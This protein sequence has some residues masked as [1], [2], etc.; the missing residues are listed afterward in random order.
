MQTGLELP[1]QAKRKRGDFPTKPRGVRKWLD[2]LAHVDVREATRRFS[3]GIYQ[4]NRLR[5][6]AKRRLEIM[7]MLRP[8]AREIFDHLGGRIQAQTLPLPERT[9]KVFDLDLQ[10]LRETAFGY[11]A[12]LAALTGS[13]WPSARRAIALAAERAL[14]ARGEIMLRCAQVYSPLPEGFWQ[15]THTVYARTEAA[16]AQDRR[17]RDPELQVAKRPR[18]SPRTMYKRLVMFAVAQTDGLRKAETERV[19]SA[20]EAWA[21]QAQLRAADPDRE[22]ASNT[23]DVD[24]RFAVDLAESSPPRPWRLHPRGSS[25]ALRVLDLWRV[26]GTINARLEEAERQ[27]RT[28]E[29][30]NPDRISSVALRRLLDNW[31][32]QAV[33]RSER[34]QHGQAVEVEVTLQ[35]IHDRCELEQ[36][37]RAKQQ[38]PAS[39]PDF[40]D[41][42]GLALQTIDRD[43]RA[44]DR[45]GFV[46]HPGH[47][48]DAA[49]YSLW[50]AVA[51]GRPHTQSFVDTELPH[52]A[53]RGDD[54]HQ[55]HW[56]LE[57]SSRSGFR[58][59]W[60]GEG[61][62]RATVGELVA[63]RLP[64]GQED[65]PRW[66]LGAVRWIQFVGEADFMAGCA[67]LSDHMSPAR[68]ERDTPKRKRRGHKPSVES[69]THALVL[70][71][72]RSR[73]QAAGVLV[74][75]H[76][77]HE[78][79]IVQLTLR[80][81]TLRVE[82]SYI[83]EH[84]G[85]FTHFDIVS[86]RR[87][88][89]GGE[90]NGAKG[91]SVWETI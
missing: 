42:A 56:I 62:S 81:R 22:G 6:P 4:L 51:R 38:G 33:R 21:Q 65:A 47:G 50:D 91:R 70:P 84:T 17:V 13:R 5:I 19:Y 37:A 18:Q 77:F 30:V 31:Q 3:E 90:A 29:K 40:T 26:I 14:T 15:R 49:H 25:A 46:T 83:R 67:A 76:M 66:R 78:G 68:V 36:Q 79:E 48:Q 2:E 71:G 57:D 44:D 75:A 23:G 35:R 39:Q 54:E 86:A 88:V 24:C 53:S 61:S 87:A 80:Q 45:Q 1:S 82:L 10:L 20:L 7:E 55:L 27:E 41:T 34:K 28:N 58:L 72:N 12:A 69:K 74:P 63:L 64:G 59:H 73:G 11:E 43:D 8:T 9:R 32:Q 16:R 52:N 60:V 89:G 85:S